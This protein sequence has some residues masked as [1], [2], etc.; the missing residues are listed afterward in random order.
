MTIATS[1]M[2]ILILSSACHPR[3]PQANGSSQQTLTIESFRLLDSE[4]GFPR[5]SCASRLW[6]RASECAAKTTA[7]GADREA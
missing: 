1:M 2:L 5:T 6:F 7:P 4:D 3:F